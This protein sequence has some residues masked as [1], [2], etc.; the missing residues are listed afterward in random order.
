MNMVAT[1]II[2]RHVDFA[3]LSRRLAPW[4]LNVPATQDRAPEIYALPIDEVSLALCPPA[5]MARIVASVAISLAIA[6][7]ETAK[8]TGCDSQS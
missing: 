1:D 5:S 3:Y 6:N 7:R 2:E 4:A 8:G